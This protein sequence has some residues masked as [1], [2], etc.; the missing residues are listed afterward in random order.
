[1]FDN[2][3]KKIMQI[4]KIVFWIVSLVSVILAFVLGFER[5]YYTTEFHAGI[6]FSLFFG[7]PIMNYVLTLFLVGFGELVENSKKTNAAK[8]SEKTEVKAKEAARIASA[9]D[10]TNNIVCKICGYERAG[11]HKE[12]P[13]CGGIE[14]K[15]RNRSIIKT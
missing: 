2:P 14:K 15:V 12:C 10:N 9:S 4:S 6:F 7:G 1:M 11:W 3:G 8:V 13:N 5:D